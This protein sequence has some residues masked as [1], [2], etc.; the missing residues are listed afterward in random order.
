MV[1]NIEGNARQSDTAI[2]AS[3]CHHTLERSCA[4][5]VYQI[6]NLENLAA[7]YGRKSRANASGDANGDYAVSDTELTRTHSKHAEAKDL[8]ARKT[9]NPFMLQPCMCSNGHYTKRTNL[10]A[11]SPKKKFL[12]THQHLIIE[13]WNKYDMRS[14]L[15]S[16][17]LCRGNIFGTDIMAAAILLSPSI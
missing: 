10:I 17:F 14:R 12:R 13:I 5:I 2:S 1:D 9:R 8:I 6:C 11:I 4:T 3:F 16:P 15:C 7:R